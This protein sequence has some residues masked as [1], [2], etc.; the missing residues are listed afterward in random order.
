MIKHFAVVA[1]LAIAGA[2]ALASVG[3]VVAGSPAHG[4]KSLCV[5]VNGMQAKQSGSATCSADPGNTAV[6]VGPGTTATQSNG[7]GNI[8]RAIGNGNSTAI[9]M[10]GNNDKVISAHDFGDALGGSDNSTNITARHACYV[11][12]NGVR[13]C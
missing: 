3:V 9:V 6:A 4:A 1:A 5:N 13:V 8:V 11:V 12:V 7:T 2:S 10:N